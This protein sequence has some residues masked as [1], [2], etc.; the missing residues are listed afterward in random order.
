MSDG[1]LVTLEN[2]SKRFSRNLKRSHWNGL[3]DLGSDIGS[4]SH[5]KDGGGGG[6]W[7]AQKRQ[8]AAAG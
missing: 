3:Q 6:R 7:A 4:S 5:G 8:S 1:L 2:V